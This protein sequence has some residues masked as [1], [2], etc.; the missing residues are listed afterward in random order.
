[1][2]GNKKIHWSLLVYLI[3]FFLF[4]PMI[5]L[6]NFGFSIAEIVTLIY[7]PLFILSYKGVIRFPLAIIIF[8]ILTVIGRLG[9]FANSLDYN[10][11]FNYTKLIFLFIIFIQ[12]ICY[13]IGRYSNLTIDKIVTSRFTKAVMLL[14]V[15]VGVLYVFCDLDKRI[16]LLSSFFPK[17]MDYTRFI[18]PRFPGL[19]INA[20]IYSFIIFIMLVFAIKSYF[21]NKNSIYLI[22]LCIIPIVLVTSKTTIILSFLSLGFFSL[23]YF[24]NNV[25]AG[26][27]VKK[28][29]QVFLALIV[30][31]GL[32][33]LGSI[34]F[35]DYIT[36][37]DR[38][39][40][41]MGN[42]ENI[43]S[44]DT[45]YVLWEMGIERIKLAPIL[46]IDVVQADMISDSIPLYFANPHNEF[47][48]YWMSLGITGLLAYVLF[49]LY[50]IYVNSL[51]KFRPEWVLIYLA[52]IIQMTFDGAF[53]TL[54][55]QFIF[56]IFL[57][58]NFKE[59]A[60]GSKQ[61]HESNTKQQS[62]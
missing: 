29:R 33:V 62:S 61:K 41:L 36:I 49:I 52:L 14:I 17:N 25:A 16:L 31:A 30:I 34:F 21:E 58:I 28:S 42:N 15:L 22:A 46:G 18:S 45:R 53:Q 44:L 13:I 23:Y 26:K 48:F 59:L 1:M 50:M 57:G 39:D 40:E 37:L 10:I 27:S 5:M 8:I 56:F 4:S 60:L 12:I 3:P 20:N 55:F 2:V 35:A 24:K 32:T 11:P 9:A 51:P 54:R 38:F 19:G 43:N 6:G 47:L 7:G